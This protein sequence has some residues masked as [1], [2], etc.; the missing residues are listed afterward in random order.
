MACP[1]APALW[2]LLLP[3]QFCIWRELQIIH[4][5][6]HP[7]RVFRGSLANRSPLRNQ[8]SLIPLGFSLIHSAIRCILLSEQ[9]VLEYCCPL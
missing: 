6:I 8:L 1:E 3:R 7:S 5:G 2:R 9:N 4:I